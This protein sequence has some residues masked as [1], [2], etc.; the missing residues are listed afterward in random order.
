MVLLCQLLCSVNEILHGLSVIQIGHRAT[1]AIHHGKGQTG[2]DLPD[3]YRQRALDFSILISRYNGLPFPHGLLLG[4][5]D[6]LRKMSLGMGLQ[7]RLIL[8]NLFFCDNF[9]H[10][11]TPS[12]YNLSAGGDK[13]APNPPGRIIALPH[14]LRVPLDTQ[15]EF[16][17]WVLNGLDNAILCPGR[18]DEIRC[19][20][21]SPPDDA[22][23]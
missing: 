8:R 9:R 12:I 20:R 1:A 6:A 23:C 15:H 21:F 17:I 3:Q 7:K 19:S 10:K 18:N 2:H 4:P 14:M 16:P 13:G 5:Q 22:C 11:Y